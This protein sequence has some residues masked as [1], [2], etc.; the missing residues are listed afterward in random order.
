MATALSLHLG[1]T[2][3]HASVAVDDRID[4][5]ALTESAVDVPAP[6]P[7]DG[8]ALVRL[9]VE[10]HARC[11]GVLD[12]VPDHLIL[13]R[14][15]GASAVDPILIE[16]ARRA[17]VPSPV[18][19][20]ETRAV[21]ALAAHGPVGVAGD[22]MPALGGTFWHRSGDAPTDP[23]P[24]VT[25]ADL[26]AGAVGPDRLPPAPSVVAVGPRTVFE[27]VVVPTR[28]RRGLPTPVLA[29]VAVLVVGTLAALLLFGNDEQ[30]ISPVPS[31]TTTP[32]PTT[33]V[34]SPTVAPTTAL[35]TTVIPSTTAVP[36]TAPPTTTVPV[37]TTETLS[38][39]TEEAPDASLSEADED[40]EASE[41]SEVS[42]LVDESAD[43]STVGSSTVV[44]PTT[45][46]PS[47]GRVTLSGV[48][49]TI[50]AASAEEVL[51][52]FGDAAGGVVDD[53][54]R[55]MGEAVGD[56]GWGADAACESAEVRRLFWSGLE[57]VL[58]RDGPEAE[59]Q[60]AQWHLSGRDSTETSLWTL[61]RI[62][63]G[64]TVADLRAA[65]PAVSLDQP[66]ERDPAG[67]FDSEPVLGD[68]IRGA[69]HRISDSGRVLLMWA[70]EACQRWTD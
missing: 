20:S 33:T 45:V 67:R 43:T 12:V 28:R 24:I 61:E 53:L 11:L 8:R 64:S 42:S 39:T 47:L 66:D 26:G 62:G 57:V 38:D 21:A 41:D 2:S 55:A 19:L 59:G 69:V 25:R 51:V 50:D 5:L 14:P 65:H 52:A 27:E 3:A 49:L 54:S 35:P 68:G 32:L 58:V 48:G 30:P 63:I 15:D 6:D 10:A 40:L 17:K 36:S 56:S 7:T 70:G 60:L 37:S 4:V 23:K 29:V 44:S 16:A 46:V 1:V 22:L 31:A 18:I 34:P 9:L 13:V